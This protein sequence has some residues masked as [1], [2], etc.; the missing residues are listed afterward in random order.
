M[1]ETAPNPAPIEPPASLVGA[2]GYVGPGLLVAATVV[3]SG[4]LIATTKTG[5]QVGIIFLWLI[6]LGCFIKVFVQ[7]ELGRYTLSAGEPTLQALDRIPGPR[8]RAGWVIWLWLAIAPAAFAIMGGVL[9]GV[10]QVMAMMLPIT[11]DYIAALAKPDVISG[12]SFD[13]RFWGTTIAVATSALLYFG[14]YRMIER[15]AVGL[16]M[17]FTLITIGNVFLLEFSA[18][19]LSAG[20]IVQGLSFGVPDRPDAWFTVLATFGIIGVGAIDLISYSYWCLEKGYARYCGPR[21]DSAAW[22]DRARGWVRVMKV[23]TFVAMA[24]YTTATVAFYLIG[25]AVLHRD[26]LDP[27]G[28][29]M[30]STL[31][32]AYVPIF[33]P[34]AKWLL[35][36]GALAVL[37]SSFL[38]GSAAAA[39]LFA[40]GFTVLGFVDGHDPEVRQRTVDRLS[41]AL[42]LVALAFFLSGWNPV[43]LI[44]IGG[45]AQT[46][47]L[48][49]VGFGAIYLR[50][51]LTDPRLAPGRAWDTAL[52]LSCVGFVVVA[53]FGLYWIFR[54]VP[55]G[56]G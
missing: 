48:P 43:L 6:I 51:K 53:G 17:L 56:T 2:L 41:L 49:V 14:R 55:G 11:G 16:V 44:L 32:A 18:Y 8:F 10:G 5:A 42:P 9:G 37:Y 21:D 36:I 4:E 52:I 1:A 34:Y 13:D 12:S 28:M 33:G 47:L 46:V 22:V 23:D 25:A 27:D 24:V 38:I 35:L 40:D 26:D 7:V 29:H 3:G 15:V 20:D 19:R 45:I 30:I 54:T 31:I 50:F 39:R